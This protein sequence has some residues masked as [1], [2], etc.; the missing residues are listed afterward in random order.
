MAPR[1]HLLRTTRLLNRSYATASSSSTPPHFRVFDRRIKEAQRTRAA[2]SP[3][4]RTVDYLRDTIASRLA[5]RLLLITRPL[6][7][8]LDLGSGACHIAKSILTDPT[9]SELIPRINKLT[10]TD[11]S[12]TL[13][14]RDDT[15][16]WAQSSPFELERLCVDEE[17]ILSDPTN[18]PYPADTFSAALSASSLHWINDLPSVLASVNTLLRPDSP[19]LGAMVGGDTLFELR[20]SLQL[21]ELERRGGVSPHVSPMADTRDVGGLMDKAGFQLLTVDVEDF[22]VDYPDMARLCMDLGWMGEGN[23]VLGREM[24]G[25]GRDVWMAAEAIYKELH[26]NEDGTVPATFRIIYMIGWKKGAGQPQPLQRGTGQVSLK[27]AL[28]NVGPS[29]GKKEGNGEKDGNS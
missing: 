12:S 25:I 6:P 14:H 11:A 13:L 28:A 9:L 26:G 5:E 22:V 17:S 7:H 3:H 21:A 19:F 1:L 27:E 29:G 20:T 8:I 16:P 15:E 23:A 24:G 18:F 4:S 10:C 2:L